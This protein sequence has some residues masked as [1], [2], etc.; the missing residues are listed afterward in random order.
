MKKAILQLL[1]SFLFLLMSGSNKISRYIFGFRDSNN[2]SP[3]KVF[4][5]VVIIFFSAT[6][7]NAVENIFQIDSSK[8]PLSGPSTIVS[9][10][11]GLSFAVI[12]RKSKKISKIKHNQVVFERVIEGFEPYDLL[13]VNNELFVSCKESGEVKVLSQL[14]FSLKKTI[15]I[16][17][18]TTYMALSTDRSI[19]YVSSPLALGDTIGMIDTASKTV[20][21]PPIYDPDLNGVDKLFT[22]NG[23][24]F[25]TSYLTPF[26]VIFNEKTREQD[27]APTWGLTFN[28]FVV[29]KTHI[30]LSSTEEGLIRIINLQSYEKEKDISFNGSP[31]RMVFDGNQY[32]Y[33]LNND[34]TGKV[35]RLDINTNEFDDEMCFQSG[36][37][38]YTGSRPY[39]A[40][41]SRDGKVLYVSNYGDDTITWHFISGKL[42]IEPRSIIVKP[43]DADVH[44]ASQN[45]IL[46]KAGGGSKNYVWSAAYGELSSLTGEEVLFTPPSGE[47]IYYVTVEDQ[48]SFASAISEIIVVD[49]RITPNRITVPN[50]NPNQFNI[51]GG[52]PPY[53]ISA[54]QGGS[55]DYNI[56]ESFFT[57][58]PPIEDGIYTIEIKDKNNA[59]AYATVELASEGVPVLSEDASRA[60]III[61]A[62]PPEVSENGIWPAIKI[63]AEKIYKILI[64]EKKFTTEQIYL[65][66]PVDLDGTG[67]G[68]PDEINRKEAG[69]L[70]EK[71]IKDAFLWAAQS[72]QLDQPLFIFVLGHGTKDQFQLNRTNPKNILQAETLSQYLDDYQQASGKE[73]VLIM[74]S[75]HSGSFIDDLAG[76]GRAIITSTGETNSAFY[77]MH[78]DNA[79]FVHSFIAYFSKGISKGNSLLESYNSACIDLSEFYSNE[80]CSKK[81]DTPNYYFQNPQYDDN[82]DGI[83]NDKLMNVNTDDGKMLGKIFINPPTSVKSNR[84]SSTPLNQIAE[85]PSLSDIADMTLSVVSMNNRAVETFSPTEEVLLKAKVGL[86][87]GSVKNVYAVLKPPGLKIPLEDDIALIS[88]PQIKLE[89]SKEIRNLESIN[90]EIWETLWDGAVYEG[91]YEIN[92][93]AQSENGGIAFSDSITFYMDAAQKPPEEPK[94][95][96]ILNNPIP[97]NGNDFEYSPD[98]RLSIGVIEQ[99]NWGYDLYIAI[100]LPD[101]ENLLFFFDSFNQLSDYDL[102]QLSITPAEREIFPK[103]QSQRKQSEELTILDMEIPEWLSK[104]E[105]QIY[106]IM[107]PQGKDPLNVPDYWKI[108]NHS[109]VIKP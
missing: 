30:Y 12:N 17:K 106:A 4:W 20:L 53:E 84:F 100:S 41:I 33:V 52:T 103:W 14:D 85:Q 5:A 104:G 46:L 9:L 29:T 24:L 23:K 87:Q 97:D 95:D 83:F 64:S 94:I 26:I 78:N 1:L 98:D 32:I 63:A 86:A 92:F 44:D 89:K 18:S 57:F 88:Y 45:S 21:N 42:F 91:C 79:S 50:Q 60:A 70:E 93:F 34:R 47:D 7:S 62:G 75:C 19:I 37:C 25:A 80:L 108:S 10:D 68:Y 82:G 59:K 13:A 77:T 54:L 36:N 73:V 35:F 56:G 3:R 61:A 72:K 43:S 48:D 31:D 28:D 66:S 65:L 39:D 71:H 6:C 16:S 38:F 15:P 109:F 69:P 22:H 102:S 58:S 27:A 107:V 74:D 90:S 11:D 105:Y 51:T 8:N 101:T 99:L 96:I 81:Y 40:V 49:I 55:I 2:L 76:P 67:D